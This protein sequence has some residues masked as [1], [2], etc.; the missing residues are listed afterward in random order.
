MN[1][2][3]SLTQPPP[4]I[5][6]RHYIRPQ[7]QDMLNPEYYL[8]AYCPPGGERQ[9][10][11]FCDRAAAVEIG[12][13]VETCIWERRPFYCV[14]VPGESAWSVHRIH[15]TLQPPATPLRSSG[16]AL[17]LAAAWAQCCVMF[18]NSHAPRMRF[19]MHA[20]WSQMLRQSWRGARMHHQ[21]SP[22]RLPAIHSLPSQPAR[23]PSATAAAMTTKW[24]RMATPLQLRHAAAALTAV[25]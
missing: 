4:Y 17:A 9:T 16:G 3:Q 10:T 6:T 7:V 15:G 19:A 1:K 12:E 24:R 8:G 20:T 23:A 18:C 25:A 14:P 2:P 5:T 21:P 22:K 11:K 13:G